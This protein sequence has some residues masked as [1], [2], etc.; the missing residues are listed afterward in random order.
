MKTRPR[1]LSTY[2]PHWV[3]VLVNWWM[4]RYGDPGDPA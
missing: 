1:P 2:L 4:K 3:K